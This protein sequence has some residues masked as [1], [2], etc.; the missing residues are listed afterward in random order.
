MAKLD[1]QESNFVIYQKEKEMLINDLTETKQ[2]MQDI[3]KQLEIMT[4]AYQEVQDGM[5][6]AVLDKELAQESF[7]QCQ[8]ELQK[9]QETVHE[10]QLELDIFKEERGI[11][12]FNIHLNHHSSG[13]G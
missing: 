13:N 4:N 11:F 7:E 2:K 5:E 8:L 6:M 12:S 10:L 1:E 3:E 9:C